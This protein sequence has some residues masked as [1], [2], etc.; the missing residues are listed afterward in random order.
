M[1]NAQK[2]VPL[3]MLMLL[4]VCVLVF[5]AIPALS[6]ASEVSVTHSASYT[7]GGSQRYTHLFDSRFTSGIC[8]HSTYG[9]VQTAP[10]DCKH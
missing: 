4:T 8:R 2:A 7:R 3:R 10:S 1:K 5:T 6:F 9:K